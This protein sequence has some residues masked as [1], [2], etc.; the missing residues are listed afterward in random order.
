[1]LFTS[2]KTDVT[3]ANIVSDKPSGEESR[4]GE[5]VLLSYEELIDFMNYYSKL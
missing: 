5:K 2:V 4:M 3:F 1:M